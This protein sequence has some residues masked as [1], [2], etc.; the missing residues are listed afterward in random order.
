MFK[1]LN[2]NTI[3]SVNFPVSSGKNIRGDGIRSKYAVRKKS[4]LKEPFFLSGLIIVVIMKEGNRE[5]DFLSISKPGQWSLN[6]L[7][8][9]D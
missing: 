3:P 1:A 4:N 2:Q 8:D 9:D 5:T 6:K 7:L